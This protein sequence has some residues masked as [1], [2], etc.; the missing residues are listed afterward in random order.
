MAKINQE[1]LGRLMLKLGVGQ[2]RAYIKIADTVNE[3][4]L[5]RHQAVLR[6]ALEQGINISKYASDEDWAAIREAAR[7][8]QL[9]VKQ[10][11]APTAKAAKR[12]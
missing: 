8:V 1:L 10:G 6:L 7:P 12:C 11:A 4:L 9:Q 5:P 2:A 3:T